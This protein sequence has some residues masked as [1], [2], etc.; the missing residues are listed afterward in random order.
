MSSR[1][2]VSLHI[3][4]QL[5]LSFHYE[6][7][8]SSYAYSKSFCHVLSR[9]LSESGANN[10]RREG[11]CPFRVVQRFAQPAA[12]LLATNINFTFPGEINYVLNHGCVS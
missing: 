1:L 9:E 5:L 2:A 10:L 6:P 3:Y 11:K 7:C 4:P 12:A 8:S